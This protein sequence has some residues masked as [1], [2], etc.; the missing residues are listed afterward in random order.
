MQKCK[1]AKNVK[2]EKYEKMKKNAKY[3]KFG[4]YGILYCQD[5][6]DGVRK[7]RKLQIMSVLYLVAQVLISDCPRKLTASNE[8][9]WHNNALLKFC[10]SFFC[11]GSE[12]QITVVELF[13]QGVTKLFRQIEMIETFVFS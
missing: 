9:S 2:N 3:A 11:P 1:D 5:R 13:R 6:L 10:S 7:N 4:K 12:A 8:H